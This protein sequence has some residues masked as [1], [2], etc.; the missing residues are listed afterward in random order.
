MTK[1]G[2][3]PVG[4]YVVSA[5]LRFEFDHQDKSNPNRKCSVWENGYLVKAK[6]PS[7]AYDKGVALAKAD[8]FR[9]EYRGKPGKWIYVG[10]SGLV[11]IYEKLNDGAEILWTDWGKHSAKASAQRVWTKKDL[12]KSLSKVIEPKL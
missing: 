4:W 6:S 5:L 2:Y 10:V 12:M 3:S 7:E 9:A 8:K 1:Q 11:P